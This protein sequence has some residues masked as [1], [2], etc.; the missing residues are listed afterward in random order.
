[1]NRVHENRI[2]LCI[3][4]PDMECYNAL[5]GCDK[6]EYEAIAIAGKSPQ[7][8]LAEYTSNDANFRR[9]LEALAQS[10]STSVAAELV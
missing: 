8:A 1:M 3:F 4:A 5:S 6:A 2:I 10:V 7:E 9:T